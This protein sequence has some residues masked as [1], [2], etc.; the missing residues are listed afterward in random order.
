VRPA[1]VAV[2]LLLLSGAAAAAEPK[3]PELRLRYAAHWNGI[4]LGDI[5]VTLK[6]GEQPDC[7]RY[8]SQADP[9]GM[10]R[11]FYGKPRELSE[12]CVAGGKVVPRRFTFERGKGGF[13]LDFDLPAGKVRDGAGREREIPPNA[14]DRF[15]LQQAVRLWAVQNERKGAG[16]SVEFALVDD[17]R[18]RQYRF[19]I[20]G[21]E[22]IALPA[23]TFDTL[24]I[25]RVDNPNRISRYWIAPEL[26]WMP[27]K[28]ESGKNGQIQLRMELRP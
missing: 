15:G 13:T 19:A 23:G 12:F 10:V 8:E 17:E 18:V 25:E 16:T 6:P 28:V 26:D 22:R 2:L 5:T 27:V 24:R 7:Y 4:T 9:V 14:Q 11:M 1:L 20:T 21:R 3:L